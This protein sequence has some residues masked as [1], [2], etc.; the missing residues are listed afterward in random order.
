M[1]NH[2]ARV[3]R[4]VVCAER[5]ERYSRTV[6]PHLAD[7]A[8]V[9]GVGHDDYEGLLQVFLV[10]GGRTEGVTEQFV[11]IGFK[12]DAT[13]EGCAEA[14]VAYGVHR[15]HSALGRQRYGGVDVEVFAVCLVRLDA[16]EVF[17][18]LAYVLQIVAAGE[19][20]G[21]VAVAEQ[22]D[23]D[24]AVA[25]LGGFLQG[26]PFVLAVLVA[27]LRDGARMGIV[28]VL[29]SEHYLALAVARVLRHALDGERHFGLL[30]AAGGR[31]LTPVGLALHFP[32]ALSVYDQGLL[33]LCAQRACHRR[34]AHQLMVGCDA[35]ELAPAAGC[36]ILLNG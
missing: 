20:L 9:G 7:A 17:H 27:V 8:V 4:I 10:Y 18:F 12:S 11:V 23:V 3:E 32:L 5:T 15:A 21:V 19:V 13:C 36:L 14:V 30:V 22:H 16:E 33:V 2:A 28:F 24:A 34:T 29:Q 31:H 35:L 1:L 25:S 6:G 26:Y